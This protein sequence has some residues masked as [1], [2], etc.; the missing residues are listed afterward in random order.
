MANSNYLKGMLCPQCGFEEEFTI[1]STARVSVTDNELDV[2]FADFNW[3]PT[4]KCVCASCGRSGTVAAFTI[5][6]AYDDSN[7][8]EVLPD[9]PLYHPDKPWLFEVGS[10]QGFFASEAEA[11]ARQRDYRAAHNFDPITG[12]RV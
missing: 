4:D 7:V 8:R 11:C 6:P 12:E 5:K 2:C 10:E 1:T 9:E 3:Q